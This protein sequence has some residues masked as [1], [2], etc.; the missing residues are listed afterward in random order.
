MARAKVFAFI[1]YK[2]GVAKTT[3]TY[4]IGCWLAERKNKKVLLIDIDP[5]TNLTFLCA[6]IG[7]WQKRK[8]RVGTIAAMY[9]RYLDKKP[10]EVK[11]YLW[12]TPIRLRGGGRHP[13]IDLVPCDID[14]IGED[15]GGGQIAGTYPSM[16]MLKKNAEQFMRDREFLVKT[17]DAIRDKY[18]YVLIDCPPNLYLMTQNALVASDY[19][20]VTAIPDHLSTIGLNILRNKVDRIDDLVKSA[21][22]MAGGKSPKRRVAKLGAV[23][24]VRVRIGGAVQT[25][26]HSS[27]MEEVRSSVGQE[28][29]FETHTTEL[30]GYTEAAENSLPVW[31]HDSNNARR[32]ARKQEYPRIVD[33][34]LEKF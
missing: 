33:E 29:C 27:K 14:L 1:N 10:L 6:S 31:L 19:Y 3:S 8:S 20:I 9:K 13:R 18:D 21:T 5:Q 16:T 15:I 4:H 2:G 24:F 25:T 28:K 32:A 17:I 23:L 30:I 34:I 12:E 22:T 11:K 7:D 26:A